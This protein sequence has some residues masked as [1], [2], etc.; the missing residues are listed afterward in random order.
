MKPWY[1][2]YD[3]SNNY[4]DTLPSFFEAQQFDWANELKKHSLEIKQELATYL[5]NQQL[6]SYFNSSM[7]SKQDSWK[8]VALKTWDINLYKNQKQFPLTTSLLNKFPQIISASFNLLESQSHI[9][10]HCGDTNAIYR[11]HLG[12][13]I[14]AQ[15]PECGFRVNDE[16]KSWQNGE[17]LIFLDA[18]HHEAWNNSS[19]ARYI[20]LIDVMREEFAEQKQQVC[21]TVLTSLFMQKHFN[22]FKDLLLRRPLLVKVLAKSLRPFASLSLRFSNYFKLF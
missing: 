13:E 2:V 9:L 16:K 8:T 6:Q 22:M 11:C 19:H 20:F 10:P 4:K 3:F 17:W 21:S 12:I 1:S 15:L 14:P 7:V 18:Y 5:E